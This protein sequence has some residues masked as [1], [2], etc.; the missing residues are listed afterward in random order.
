MNDQNIDGKQ[1]ERIRQ[2][3]DAYLSNE[4]L[5]ETTS[6]VLK[7]LE[8]CPACAQELEARQRVRNALR[9]AAGNLMPPDTLLPAVERR[10]RKMQ[11]AFLGVSWNMQWV[12]AVAAVF[13]IFVGLGAFQQWRKVT[14]GKQMVASVIALGVSD[15]VQC[16]IQGHNY[17]DV[18]NPPDKLR[19]KLGPEY[20]GLL[21]V[22]KQKLPG[23][24]ILEAHICSIKDSPRKY[25]HFVTRGRGTLLSVILTRSEGEQLPTSPAFR[26]GTSDGVDL[27]EA[28][29]EGMN[30]VGFES[31]AYWGF[32][33]S[34]LSP[35]TTLE[36][37]SELAPPMKAALD[38]N[39]PAGA[40]AC[41][42]DFFSAP[43]RAA[44][45]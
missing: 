28:H 18:A 12:V 17:P 13:T 37:A 20:A 11:P 38:A 43:E 29:I 10:L 22:V 16:T 44:R 35:G 3:L 9:R 30:A 45:P 21:D 36:I 24:E 8:T 14:R 19:Q 40:R 42:T 34:D 32:V 25:V 26:S 6:G 15:H 31:K 41:L 33:V 7:H 5:V 1:C 23:F 4:L 2:H 39:L 27:Y